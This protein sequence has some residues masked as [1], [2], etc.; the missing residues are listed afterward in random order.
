MGPNALIDG[1]FK[2]W[3]VA[4]YTVGEVIDKELVIIL[5]KPERIITSFT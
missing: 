5:A 1:C 2:S 3:I 4:T